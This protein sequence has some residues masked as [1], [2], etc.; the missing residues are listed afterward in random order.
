M[1]RQPRKRRLDNVPTFDGGS[2]WGTSPPQ[3]HPFSQTSRPPP[4]TALLASSGQ[5]AMTSVRRLAGRREG[6]VRLLPWL[7]EIT[8]LPRLG[9]RRWHDTDHG[10]RIAAVFLVSF[11][12]RDRLPDPCNI[13][14]SPTRTRCDPNAGLML[15]RRLR[16]RPSIR[17]ALAQCFVFT[18]PRVGSCCS[19]YNSLTSSNC[20]TG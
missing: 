3:G 2:Y 17:P 20:Q 18:V 4:R 8:P 14:L 10:S 16:R 13:R 15:G 11:W 1:W 6:L 12:Q 9:P 5:S 19:G 7:D